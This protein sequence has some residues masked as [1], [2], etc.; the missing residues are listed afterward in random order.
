MILFSA[1]HQ[2]RHRKKQ[3]IASIASVTIGVGL[4]IMMASMQLGFENDFVERIIAVTPHVQITSE[5]LRPRPE[6]GRDRYELSR[7]ERIR[8]FDK[9]MTI[10]GA[11]FWRETLAGLPGVTDISASYTGQGLISFG[12]KD[13]AVVIRGVDPVQENR[14]NG[15]GDKLRLGRLEHFA[16]A[17]NGIIL[18]SGIARRLAAKPGDT[19][20]L[21]GETGNRELFR[22][23]DLYQSGITAYDNRTLFIL[24][25]NAEAFFGASGPNEFN[26]KLQDPNSAE[27]VAA[28]TRSLTGLE[29]RDWISE[30]ENIRGELNRRRMINLGIV[31]TIFVVSAF[32]ITNIMLMSV[33]NKKRDIA[34]MQAFGVSRKA[35]SAI[36]LMQGLILGLLGAL[37]GMLSGAVL[38]YALSV[39]PVSFTATITRQGFPMVWAWHLFLIP[40]AVGIFCGLAASSVPAWRASRFKPAEVIRNG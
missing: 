28:L 19:V 18:G 14:I 37:G 3:T 24:L 5:R 7:V 9:P 32:G 2:I 25:K 27:R 6:L 22:I 40:A 20:T 29:S 33:M 30:N 26:L 13:Q 31:G 21:I 17:P 36:Y 23:I 8:A 10:N 16:T 35:L 4:S 38:I 1:W 39:L 11:G 12:N 15:L 34:I